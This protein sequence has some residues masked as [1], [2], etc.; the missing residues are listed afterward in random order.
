MNKYIL[1]V[2]VFLLSHAVCKAEQGAVHPHQQS[3]ANVIGHVVDTATHEHLAYATV[4]VKGTT[5]GV[6]TDATGHY[7]L[8]NLPDG[9]YTLSVSMLGYKT[10]ERTVDV[11]KNR[12]LEAN[13]ALESDLLSLDEVVVTANRTETSRKTSPTIVAVT[14]SKQFE[15]TASNNLAE[16]MN[17]QSGLRMGM[18]TKRTTV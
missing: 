16:T 6:T 15:T 12:T 18:K 9:T 2:T 14:T 17:F 7:F 3:D 4:A 11:V 10:V 5:F 8:K 13:F 1:G